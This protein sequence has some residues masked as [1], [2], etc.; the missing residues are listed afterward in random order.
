M[1]I[2]TGWPCGAVVCVS[3]LFGLSVGEAIAQEYRGRVQ[4][5]VS[6]PSQASIAGAKV[7]LKNTGTGIESSR[8][9]D[10]IGHYLFDLVQPGTYSVTV[11]AMGFQ[12]NLHEN[13][14]VLTRGDVTVDASM[15]VG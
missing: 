4:G 5:I 9:T 8:Q 3:V 15:T 13:V 2:R 1:Q 6:D 10:S 14:T 7:T 11:E 12:R